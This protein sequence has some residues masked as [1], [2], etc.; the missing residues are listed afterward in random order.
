MCLFVR[1]LDGKARAGLM[2]WLDV[3]SALTAFVLANHATVYTSGGLMVI[4]DYTGVL[5]ELAGLINRL[6][7]S[8]IKPCSIQ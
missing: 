4:P 7:A 8:I 1:L 2:Q 3:E 6:F 5:N